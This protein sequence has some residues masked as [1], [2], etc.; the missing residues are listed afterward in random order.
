MNAMMLDVTQE[1]RERLFARY[2]RLFARGDVIFREGE[3]GREM[4]V[5]QEGRVRI[6]KT[7]RK[8]EKSLAILK[9]GDFFGEMA[10]LNDHVRTATAAAIDDC[11]ILAFDQTTFEAMI[12]SHVGITVRLIK[13]LAS[14]L[15]DADDQ[16]ENLML[17]DNQSKIVNTLLKLAK[18]ARAAE[19]AAGEGVVLRITPLELSSKVGLDVDTVKRGMYQLRESAFID[20]QEERV[21]IH[22]TEELEKLY[23]LLGMKE[24]LEG[25]GGA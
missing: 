20:I 17:K 9:P 24:E 5:I 10:I 25:V 2:G 11:K 18:V 16:I 14:R 8:Q 3:P 4:Y 7:V 1:Q 15:R 6:L 23:R 12:T 19:G 22:N 13:R 21:Y